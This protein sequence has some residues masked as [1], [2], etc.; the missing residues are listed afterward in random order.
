MP[1][2][3]FDDGPDHPPVDPNLV[4]CT[5]ILL[6]DV[7]KAF[8]QIDEICSGL[9]PNTDKSYKGSEI[10]KKILARITVTQTGVRKDYFKNATSGV[11][12]KDIE[13][14]ISSITQACEDPADP[15][16]VEAYDLLLMWQRRLQ[17]A[18]NGNDITEQDL[19]ESGKVLFDGEKFIF[20]ERIDHAQFARL[21]VG[22]Y[23]VNGSFKRAE[24]PT[25]ILSE[26]RPAI[27][28][29]CI[30]FKPQ[31][32]GAKMSLM[33]KALTS[34]LARLRQMTEKRPRIIGMPPPQA[35]RHE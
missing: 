8:G 25:R 7:D 31:K 24:L 5:V 29:A 32:E 27:L 3:F 9:K 23:I 33:E 4:Q 17:I 15:I 28:Q 13:D 11:N 12:I 22:Q 1:E 16:H 10:R 21:A 30:H 34:D 18:Q 6:A 20:P 35:L 2:G 26:W 14:A 19:F